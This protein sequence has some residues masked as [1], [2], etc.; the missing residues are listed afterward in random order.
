MNQLQKIIG[1]I[2][3]AIGIMLLV[4]G[5]NAA[6]SLNSQVENIFNGT[7]TNRAIYFYVGGLALII[8]GLFQMLRPR[9]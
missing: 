6:Q 8:Y 4:W 5:H 9:K 2:A 1:A 7:P 3:L